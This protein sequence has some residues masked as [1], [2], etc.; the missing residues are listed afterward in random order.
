MRFSPWLVLGLALG[1][2]ENEISIAG[3][4]EAN[5]VPNPPTLETPVRHDRIVQVTTPQVDVL[6]VI[7]DSCSMS[8]EQQK[9]AVNFPSFIEFFIDS[10]LNWHIGVISTDTDAPTQK[11]RLQGAAS[12]RFLDPNTPNPV[13]LFG[14]MATLGTGGAID[15]RGRRATQ[16]ALTDPQLSGYNAGFYREDAS[17]NIVVIS[18]END[19]SANSPTRNEFINFLKTLKEDPEL[20]TFSSIVGPTGGCPTADAG[21][22]YLAVTNAVG[23]IHESIC[24]EDWVPVLEELGLQ[25]AGLRREYFLSELP[26]PGTVEVWVIDGDFTYEGVDESLLTGDNFDDVCTSVCFSYKYEADRNS[27]L[28]E[29]FVPS[30]LAEINIRYELLSGFQPTAEGDNPLIGGE[31]TMDSDS[32]SDG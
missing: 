27:I 12:Y 32:D 21:V 24:A 13:A 3:E 4:I 22:E 20:V 15:E 6:W 5:G 11:G 30:P 1:G 29:E 16:M 9:L 23:G 8:E 31:G 10:G 2:C 28:M 19:S 26:V 18:D 17:L 25:A 14:Q 7:D